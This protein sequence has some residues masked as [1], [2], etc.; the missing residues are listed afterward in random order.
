MTT[1][2]A[3]LVNLHCVQNFDEAIGRLLQPHKELKSVRRD[4]EIKQM[5]EQIVLYTR[6]TI[7]EA[8]IS[9]KLRELPDIM[10][11]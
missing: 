9:T 2:F 11:T 8:D 3:N 10:Q 5:D 4:N 1:F 6:G 7:H